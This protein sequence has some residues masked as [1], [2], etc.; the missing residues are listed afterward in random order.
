M[1]LAPCVQKKAYNKI[2]V[3]QQVEVVYAGIGLA[4][5]LNRS[6]VVRGGCDPWCLLGNYAWKCTCVR[7]A[8]T[9]GTAVNSTVCL[10]GCLLVEGAH[11]PAACAHTHALGRSCWC[12]RVTCCVPRQHLRLHPC[13]APTA[14]HPNTLFNPLL[15]TRRCQSWRATATG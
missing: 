1:F 12:T 13:T 15:C 2:G 10:P 4:A 7:C 3:R 8:A 11:Q 14:S 6:L 5:M 9:A